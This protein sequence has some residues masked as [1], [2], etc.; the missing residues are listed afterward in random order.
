MSEDFYKA[1][2]V[3]R[4]ASQDEIKKAYQKMAAKN[5]PDANPDDKNAKARFQEIQRAYEVLSDDD[6]IL[7]GA[8]PTSLEDATGDLNELQQELGVAPGWIR[9]DASSERIE[10][11]LSLAE[12][13]AEVLEVPVLLVEVHPTHERLE[14]GIVH[15]NEHR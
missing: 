15:L 12:D 13:L 6:T 8:I 10:L 4:S 14:V 1:L 7:F 2:G 9:Y 5:H 11:P 3:G